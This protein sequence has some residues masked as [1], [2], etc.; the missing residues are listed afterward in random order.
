MKK[1]PCKKPCESKESSEIRIIWDSEIQEKV[2]Q[3][4]AK[5][6]ASTIL[7]V[8]TFVVTV[9]NLVSYIIKK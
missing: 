8:A 9:S 1:T 2:N 6:L 5:I 3:I 7:L 4:E